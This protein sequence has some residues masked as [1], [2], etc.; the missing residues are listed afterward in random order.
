MHCD[1]GLADAET[2]ET[3]DAVAAIIS[4]VIRAGL[5]RSGPAATT[6]IVL[7]GSGTSGRLAFL[8]ARAGNA[9]LA[10]AGLPPCFQYSCAGGDMALF[11]AREAPEDNIE[12]GR[13]SLIAAAGTATRVVYI[14]ISCGLSAPF[15]A[16]QL[17]HCLEHPDTFTPVLLG[18][19]LPA[20]ARYDRHTSLCII[21]FV[22]I[23]LYR[24]RIHRHNSHRSSQPSSVL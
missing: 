12:L 22:S 5:S 10:H 6:R 9:L 4:D 16:A 17:W 19:N 21:S 14:G 8:C 7:A 2:H 1:K 13:D 18:F 11:A 24:H 3:I 15:V 23:C 20:Q